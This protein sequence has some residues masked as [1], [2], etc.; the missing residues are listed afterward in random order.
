MITNHIVFP[1]DKIYLIKSQPNALFTNFPIKS[2]FDKNKLPSFSIRGLIVIKSPI[3]SDL[4]IW[5]T[6]LK[7]GTEGVVFV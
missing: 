3:L 7:K 5:E 6:Q 2:S 1:N 4:I